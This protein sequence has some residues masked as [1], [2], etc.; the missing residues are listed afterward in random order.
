MSLEGDGDSGHK[1]SKLNPFE[2][3]EFAQ[4]AKL[5]GDSFNLWA[6][7]RAWFGNKADCEA[8]GEP[9]KGGPLKPIEHY[10]AY[11]RRVRTW[12]PEA[13]EELIA[14]SDPAA[15]A[16]FNSLADEFNARLDSMEQEEAMKFVKRAAEIIYQKK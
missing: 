4:G 7:V 6:D 15:V 3:S 16:A 14:I 9:F 5:T 11:Y 8:F 13:V 1:T 10:E 2:Q 12:D